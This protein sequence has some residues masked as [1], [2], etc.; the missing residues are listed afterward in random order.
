VLSLKGVRSITAQCTSLR[1]TLHGCEKDFMSQNVREILQILRFELNY[2]EQG[3][4]YRDRALLG[5]ESPFLG[6]STC[7]N[8]GDPLRTHACRECLLHTFVPDDKQNEE[9]PCHY[10]P[11]N[12]SGETIAQLIEKKDP[13]R[14]VKVLELWLRTTIK[15]LEATLEDET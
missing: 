1:K 13:E 15:R 12:D 2:L 14:M 10:I 7:I 3:G 11:L 5:T 9:N 6:T 4:F 8:F